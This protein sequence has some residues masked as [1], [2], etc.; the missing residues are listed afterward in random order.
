MYDGIYTHVYMVCI[1]PC[2]HG[3]YTHLHVWCIHTCM[4]G[5]YTHVCMVCIHRG[6]YDAYT[7]IDMYG[8]YTHNGVCSFLSKI[9]AVNYLWACIL[10]VFGKNVFR[11]GNKQQSILFQ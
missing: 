7:H 5:V 1:H 6:V 8:V 11:L 2:M 10:G 9:T 3:V 4:Y